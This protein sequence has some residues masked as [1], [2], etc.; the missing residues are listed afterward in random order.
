MHEEL[1]EYFIIPFHVHILFLKHGVGH[2]RHEHGVVA[3]DGPRALVFFVD[4][5][6]LIGLETLIVLWCKQR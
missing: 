3:D 2:E 1:S 4:L 6:L 5:F